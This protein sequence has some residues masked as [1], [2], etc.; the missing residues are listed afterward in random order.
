METATGPDAECAHVTVFWPMKSCRHMSPG[1]RSENNKK[2]YFHC[3]V[4]IIT[5][6][7]NGNGFVVVITFAIKLAACYSKPDHPDF[8][9]SLRELPKNIIVNREV[10]ILRDEQCWP[11]GN[12]FASHFRFYQ[13]ANLQFALRVSPTAVKQQHESSHGDLSHRI[14]IC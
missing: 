5:S 11:I 3:T 12:H 14:T 13:F 7:I 9:R 1:D 10:G 8:A 2:S 6:F 4:I